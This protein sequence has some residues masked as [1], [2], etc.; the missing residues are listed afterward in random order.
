M[1]IKKNNK[2][3][4]K[5]CS[6]NYQ[7]HMIWWIRNYWKGTLNESWR[8]HLSI[9]SAYHLTTVTSSLN[10]NNDLL[11]CTFFFSFLTLACN[12]RSTLHF[13]YTFFNNTYKVHLF[14]HIIK[15]INTYYNFFLNGRIFQIVF[16]NKV[17][18]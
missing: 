1:R 9:C 11:N 3:Y 6:C 10:N 18:E 12:T 2:P 7:Q 5:I 16:S 17:A 14:W 4:N 13:I 8:A 15:E